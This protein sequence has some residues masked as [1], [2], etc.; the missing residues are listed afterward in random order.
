M[1]T[2]LILLLVAMLP[3][4]AHSQVYDKPGNWGLQYKRVKVDTLF[5]VAPTAYALI[6]TTTLNTSYKLNVV[7]KSIIDGLRLNGFETVPGVFDGGAALYIRRE[8]C[9]GCS[10]DTTYASS[11]HSV[12]DRSVLSIGN[13]ASFAAFDAL[14]A[15]YSD[16]VM[17]MSAMT[18]FQNNSIWD[19]P[20]GSTLGKMYGF[21]SV[22]VPK[23]GTVNNIYDFY[24]HHLDATGSPATIG[25]HYAF[26]SEDFAGAN[27]ASRNHGIYIYGTA[28]D[29]YFAGNVGIG[30]TNRGSYKLEVSGTTNLNGA[31]LVNGAATIG[32]TSAGSLRVNNTDG[33]YVG[34]N[35]SGGVPRLEL[36]NSGIAQGFLTMDAAGH[37]D[38]DR[39]VDINGNLVITGNMQLTGAG[40]I[41]GANTSSQLGSV[42]LWAA[43]STS[44]FV[45][46]ARAGVARD[47]HIGATTANGNLVFNSAPSTS[48]N[49]SGTTMMTLNKSTGFLGIK[50]SPLQALH[51]GGQVR[52]DTI[53]TVTT[54]DSVLVVEDGVIKQILFKVSATATL[55]FPN[56]SANDQSDLT[57]SVT[58]AAL[59]DVVAI[60]VPNGSTTQGSYFAWVSAADTVTVRFHNT[61]GGAY[62]PASGDFKAQVFK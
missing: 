48:A 28:S 6:G 40:L 20:V 1:K 59:G 35:F 23:T 34:I 14:P 43:T 44:P 53:L 58:G 29:N 52:I 10:T 22:L 38:F 50:V 25:D 18:G 15:I 13:N 33:D 54:Y 39:A 11:V 9:T 3:F 47:W 4:M 36:F 19:Y 32:G 37:F 30:D 7:G 56:T 46:L 12:I 55:D 61:S 26:Y 62:D 57:V 31:T 45:E 42:S 5:T 27:T 17:N 21:N 8:H 2:F 41:S 51:V 60:G 16:S 49:I 24:A